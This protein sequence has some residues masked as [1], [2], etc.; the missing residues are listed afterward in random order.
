LDDR[1]YYQRL[2]QGARYLAARAADEAER[3]IHLGWANRYFRLASE[4]ATR[5]AG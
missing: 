5:P 4:S 2:E 1:T 3:R